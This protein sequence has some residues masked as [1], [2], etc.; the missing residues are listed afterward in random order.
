MNQLIYVHPDHS[1]RLTASDFDSLEVRGYSSTTV[2]YDD[3]D[4]EFKPYLNS[5]TTIKQIADRLVYSKMSLPVNNVGL[6]NLDGEYDDIIDNPTPGA[7][8]N[9]L[10]LS[11]Y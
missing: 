11:G 1:K 2:F 4:I 10:Y 7:D 6:N 3:N 5:T 8:A 9:V